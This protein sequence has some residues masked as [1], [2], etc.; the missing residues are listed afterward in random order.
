MAVSGQSC[1]VIFLAIEQELAAGGLGDVMPAA[2]FQ[3]RAI[4]GL[5][6]L[7]QIQNFRRLLV[8]VVEAVAGGSQTFVKHIHGVLARFFRDF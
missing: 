5:V 3:H 2:G 8:R 6:Q 4:H 1:F 7:P